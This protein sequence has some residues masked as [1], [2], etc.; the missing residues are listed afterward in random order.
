MVPELEETKVFLART[1]SKLVCG[2][3][4][5]RARQYA[6]RPSTGLSWPSTHSLVFSFFL[7]KTNN[8]TEI[9]SRK[10]QRHQT[11]LYQKKSFLLA[12][13][14]ASWA[15]HVNGTLSG[16]HEVDLPLHFFNKFESSGKK[17]K[18]SNADGRTD[19]P[20]GDVITKSLNCSGQQMSSSE[21]Q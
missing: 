3:R 7:H 16:A 5:D 2:I 8:T 10:S 20:L 13:M 1:S 11:F 21:A 19:K 18:I 4:V 14:K 6:V 15:L 12:A 17:I 9:T